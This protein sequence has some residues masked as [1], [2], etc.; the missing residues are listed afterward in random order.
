VVNA[1]LRPLYLRERYPVL[2]VYRRLGGTKDRSGR[3]RKMNSKS[4]VEINFPENL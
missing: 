4:L 2:I 1:T 3:A